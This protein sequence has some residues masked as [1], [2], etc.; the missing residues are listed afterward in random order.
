MNEK[1]TTKKFPVSLGKA[2]EPTSRSEFVIPSLSTRDRNAFIGLK[3]GRERD[4]GVISFI[5]RKID[6]DDVIS[7]LKKESKNIDSSRRIINEYI[8][9]L[10]TF[11]IGNVISIQYNDDGTFILKKEANRASSK[12]KIRLP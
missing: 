4:F 10:Q 8:K 11:K 7:K 12:S 2:G 9:Q 6:A 5:G 3:S 1:H